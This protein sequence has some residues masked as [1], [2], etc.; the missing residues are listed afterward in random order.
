MDE[1][2]FSTTQKNEIIDIT[3]EVSDIVKKSKINEG[4]CLVYTP[5]AT[6][7]IILNENW[8]E[9]VQEDF[10]Q[11]L[12]EI[13]PEGRW[14]HDKQDGNGASHVKASIVGPSETMIMKDGR[15]VLGQWQNI[16]FCEFD[17]PRQERKV[18]VQII[19]K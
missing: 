8:D 18:F 3:E 17:G 2:I 11:M 15:L 10:L 13:A 16:F 12:R 7:A 14:K 1:I 9:S 4:I 6:A 19:K 5:H